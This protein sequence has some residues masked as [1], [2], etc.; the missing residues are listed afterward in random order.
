MAPKR[1]SSDAIDLDMPE[2]SCKV[3]HLSEKLKILNEERKE[4][5]CWDC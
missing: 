1:K 3:L 5:V 2:R 4:I